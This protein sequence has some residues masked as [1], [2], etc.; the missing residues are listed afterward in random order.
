MHYYQENQKYFN[1]YLKLVYLYSIAINVLMLLN[2]CRY[3]RLSYTWALQHQNLLHHLVGY[4]LF[5]LCN[6]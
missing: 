4:Q 3:I 5:R 6:Q 2:N 1:Y